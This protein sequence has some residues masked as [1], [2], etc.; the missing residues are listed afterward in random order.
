LENDELVLTLLPDMSYTLY[1]K[2]TEKEKI[3]MAGFNMSLSMTEG[4]AYF[5]ET[6]EKMDKAAFLKTDYRENAQ[7]VLVPIKCDAK[8]VTYRYTKPKELADT[9]ITFSIT[10]IA[11]SK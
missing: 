5:L 4:T 3:G 7:T 1:D 6:G 11:K 10:E 2:K 9:E 8:N